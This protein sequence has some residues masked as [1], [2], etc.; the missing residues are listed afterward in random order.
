MNKTLK[1]SLI[2]VVVI[3]I[4]VIVYFLLR[5]QGVIGSFSNCCSWDSAG[6][7]KTKKVNGEC[8]RS[9]GPGK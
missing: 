8:P 6:N 1:I 3:I 2:A 5:K 4:A 7:C 9:G